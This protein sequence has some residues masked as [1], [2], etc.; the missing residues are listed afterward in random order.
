MPLV[1]S[2]LTVILVTVVT[3]SQAEAYGSFLSHACL[4]TAEEEVLGREFMRYVKRRCT[5][6]DDPSITGYVTKVGQQI[7]EQHSSPP[8]RFRFY[9]VKED[10]YNAFAAPAG[11]VFIY[12]GLLAAMENEEE[13][14]GILAHE[15]AHVLCRHISE[16]IDRSKKIGLATLAGVLTGV[17]LGGSPTVTGAITTGS[18][19]AGE[20]L[21]LS[22]SR[23]NE[24]EA[25]QVGL[26][27][28]T[29]AGYGGEGLLRILHKIREKNW[30][31]SKQIPSYLMTHPAIV[32]RMGYLDTWIQAHPGWRKSR[33]HIDRTDFQKMRIRVIALYG[34]TMSAHN[35]FDAQ[36]RKSRD[37]ALVY[38]GKGLLFDR[39]AKRTE[40][41]KNFKQAVELRPFDTDILRDLGKTYFHMGKYGKAQKTL[42]EVVSAN[43]KDV[44]AH[45][46]L[47]RVQMETGDLNGALETFRA[48]EKKKANY[49]PAIY[50]LAQTY[51]KLGKLSEAHYGLGIYYKQKGQ[52]KIARFHLERALGLFADNPARQREINKTLKDLPQDG[53]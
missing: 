5:I 30:F 53:N 52:F 7:V 15:I 24:M 16:R 10:I 50:Y 18:I 12:T 4:T 39:E 36:L 40:A 41:L 26:K 28:L 14:A 19:A 38:Y 1:K 23:E 31:G 21:S 44:E 13:L 49:L 20:S 48:L 29:K 47:G 46:L 51:G 34:D 32:A 35:F 27:Y 42:S 43:S 45:F 25:D 22:Y 37:D 2:V 33:R 6:I 11:H 17:F 3:L 9:V 8:F